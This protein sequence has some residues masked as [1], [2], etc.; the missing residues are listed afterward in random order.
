MRI[1]KIWFFFL[2]S[3]WQKSYFKEY[4]FFFLSSIHHF[5]SLFCH[6]NFSVIIFNRESKSVER[7]VNMKIWML[8][9][10][11]D[12]LIVRSYLQMPRKPND[13]KIFYGQWAVGIWAM[14]LIDVSFDVY[15]S[16]FMCLSLHRTKQK[17]KQTQ[18]NNKNA[19]KSWCLR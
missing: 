19:G 7:A 8:M 9:L 4:C 12:A 6:L 14:R 13:I 15:L 3:I 5:K 1:L 2:P 18:Q 10:G 17:K 11:G 16:Y